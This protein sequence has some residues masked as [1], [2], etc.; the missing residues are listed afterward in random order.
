MLVYCLRFD[1]GLSSGANSVGGYR[2]V[3]GFEYC[4]SAVA[5]ADDRAV[6]VGGVGGD[7]VVAVVAVVVAVV[8]VAAAAAG[9]VGYVGVADGYAVGGADWSAPAGCRPLLERSAE[10]RQVQPGV[11]ADYDGVD[12][13]RWSMRLSSG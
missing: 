1:V 9:E 12:C 3:A 5:D 13:W 6:D 10:R 4:R 2:I 11:V 8:V 7:V